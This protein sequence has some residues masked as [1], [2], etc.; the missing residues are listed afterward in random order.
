MNKLVIVGA[1][2]HTRDNAPWDDKSFDIWTFTHHAHAKWCKRFDAVIEVHNKNFYMK[3][4]HDKEYF[5]WLKNIEQPVYIIDAH[6]DIKS[7]VQYPFDEIKKK[8]LANITVSDKPIENFCSSADYTLALAIYKG[9]KSIDIYGIEMAHSSEYKNQQSSFTFWVGVAIANGVKVN[10]NCT[11][12]LFKK[13]LYG[14]QDVMTE[15][16]KDYV[17][18]MKQ[19]ITDLDT[20][21]KMLDGAL[22]FADQLIEDS[23][24]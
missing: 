1:E 19:Q 4:Y 22:K 16:V 11:S 10:L 14:T 5:E 24:L 6:A 21:A 3:G 20:K 8:L 9:Y 17:K 2:E 7:A 15:R 13:P 12:G 23:K 18:G